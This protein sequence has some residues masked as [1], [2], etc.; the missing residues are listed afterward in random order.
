[1]S[2]HLT[3]DLKPFFGFVR[4]GSLFLPNRRISFAHK[5]YYTLFW[6]YNYT[7]AMLENTCYNTVWLFIEAIDQ[8]AGETSE[9]EVLMATEAETDKC[10]RQPAA[11]AAGNVKCLSDPQAA[12]LFIAE[13]VSEPWGALIQG[14][15]TTG[16]QDRQI[17]TTDQEIQPNPRTENSLRQSMPNLIIS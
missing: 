5:L 11:T 6:R 1:L 10:T 14:A 15:I 4:A 2:K 17:L 3:F 7:P 12:S 13:I 9:E 8:A 16:T